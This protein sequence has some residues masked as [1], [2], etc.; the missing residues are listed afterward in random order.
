MPSHNLT[1]AR[2]ALWNHAGK[3][4]D[5]IAWYC[6]SVLIARGLGVELNGVLAGMVSGIHLLLAVSSVGLEV[7][8]NKFL[9]QLAGDD[10]ASRA[11]KIIR[12]AALARILLYLGVSAV[13]ILASRWMWGDPLG[14]SP[15]ILVT[16][17]FYGLLRGLAPLAA[18]VLIAQWHTDR[19]AVISGT[20]RLLELMILVVLYNMGMSLESVILVLTGTFAIQLLGY[21]MAAKKY[22]IGQETA[23]PM[24]PIWIFGTIFWANTMVDYFLGR[25]G[26]ILFLT[27][28]SP[29]TSSAALYD[30]SYSILQ[31]GAMVMTMGFSG[32][33]L[34]AFAR[35]ALG[36][37]DSMDRFYGSLVRITSLLMIPVMGFLFVVASDIIQLLYTDAYAGA[38]VVLQVMLLFRITS[39]L[40]AGGE[41][42]DY[43]LALNKVGDVVWIGVIGAGVTVVM[44]LILIPRF[45]VVGAAWAAGVGTL[46]ANALGILRVR[47]YGSA[48]IQWRTWGIVLGITGAAGLVAHSL[49]VPGAQPAGILIRGFVYL[50]L[51]SGLAMVFRPLEFHDANTVS[52]ISP[53]LQSVVGRLARSLRE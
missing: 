18:M 49:P 3:L 28:L 30:I 38:S 16:L 21:L 52:S 12:K 24:R 2:N 14:F 19:A 40:F 53:R 11:R 51:V 1:V 13:V 47:Q 26:D 44:H 20:T 27:L 25:Q 9:P 46:S 50:G 42:A 35:L 33:T 5:Y 34:A 6:S 10:I 7:A 36:A 22:W 29:S 39:R 48:T 23:V 4:T 43:L 41:N 45:D 32:V 37:R 15:S 17:F 31:A 8:I